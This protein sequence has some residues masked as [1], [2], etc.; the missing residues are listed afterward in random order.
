MGMHGEYNQL[1]RKKKYQDS[2]AFHFHSANGQ[3]G[4]ENF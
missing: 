4:L 3:F 2:R 1:D